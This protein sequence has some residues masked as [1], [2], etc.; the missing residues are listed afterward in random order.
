MAELEDLRARLAEAEEVVRAIR[1][2]EVDAV[3]VAGG[4]GEQGYTLSGADRIYRQ[5]IETMREGAV[6]VSAA[7]VILY[8][9][10]RLAEMVGRPLQQ[11]LGTPLRNYLPP[12]DQWVVDGIPR[13]GGKEASPREVSLMAS[14]GRQVPVY[15][16]AS[17]LPSQGEERTTL[18]VL[19]DLTE[20]KSYERLVAAERL[21]RLILEQAAEVIIMCNHQGRVTRVSQAAQSV[22]AGSPLLKPFAEAFPLQTC[23]PSPFSLEPVLRGETVRDVDVVMERNG[24]QVA[25]IL[26]AGPLHSGREILGCVITLTDITER[27]RAEAARVRLTMAIEQAAEAVVVTDAK[28]AIEYVNPAFERTTGYARAEVLGANPRILKS[29]NQGPDLYRTLWKTI[30]SGNTWRGRLVNKKKSGEL[31][32]EEATISPVRDPAG[33]ITSFVAVKRDITNDLSLEAQLLQSQKM[34]GFGRLAGGVAHDFNNLLSVILSYTQC[35]IDGVRPGDL[36]GEDLLEVKK[37]ADRAVTLTRQLLAFSRK[38]VLQ[39]VALDLNPTATE[40]EKMLRRVLGSDIEFV[41]VLAPDLGVVR[42]DPGQIE[43]V[44]MNLAVNARDAMPEGGRLTIETSNVDIEAEHAAHVGTVVPGP[45]VLLAISDTGCG[46]DH[47]TLARLFEPFFTTKAKGRGT[48]LGLSTVYGIVKQSGGNIAVSSAPGHGSTFKIYLPRDLSVTAAPALKRSFTPPRVT[49]TETILVVED[50]ELLRKVAQRTLGASGYTVLTAA[51]GDAAVEASRRYAG[52]IQLLLTDVVMPGM[53]ARALA[54]A[55]VKERPSLK[56]LYMSGYTDDSIVQRGV[57]D[58]GTHFLAKPFTGASLAG[59]VREVLDG[60]V[61]GHDQRLDPVIDPGA[62][63][64]D[65]PPDR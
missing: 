22:C 49:G 31:F 7:G 54:D 59:K 45:Y 10:A 2:G 61:S 16:S 44:L 6:T 26:N 60:E 24:E 47:R 20:H 15:L 57:L 36:L 5:F 42:A 23:G 58:A 27:N 14:D 46:M 43:Q 62:G 56:V 33:V 9:N 34:E 3:V 12:A 65:Q 35:A 30:S 13:P 40:V 25:L 39:P 50:E 51:N 37:A 29:G 38:Q 19:T 18:Y 52:D 41:L 21:A 8:C 1:N 32:T 63:A 64:E 11:I 17:H 53:G 4:R 55:L 28:G 48:G